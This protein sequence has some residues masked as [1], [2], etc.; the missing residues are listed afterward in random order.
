MDTAFVINLGKEFFATAFIIVAPIMLVGLTVGMIV[1]IFQA[2]TQLNE[3]TLNFAPRILASAVAIIILGPWM[4]QK[5]LGFT[6]QIL[7][8]IPLYI[9]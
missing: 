1:T 9:K 5:L 8:N 4:L 7:Y 3:A 6:Y 2:V